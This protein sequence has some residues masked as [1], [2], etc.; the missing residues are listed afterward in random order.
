MSRIIVAGVVI[1]AL[2]V[3]AGYA[4]VQTQNMRNADR[5][6]QETPTELTIVLTDSGFEPRE[7]TIRQGGT[8]TFINETDKPHW[9]ASNLH[10][11]HELY[12][13][14]DPLRPL[15][16]DEEWSFTFE[17]I[18]THNYHDH[19]RAYFVGKIHVVK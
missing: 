4:F 15:A 9:P 2:A 19:I 16:A 10:P 17:R 14:F 13:E 5:T 18:G 7:V 1:V 6:P 11:T 3:V 8:I 12:A